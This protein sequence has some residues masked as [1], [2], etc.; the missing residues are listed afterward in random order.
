MHPTFHPKKRKQTSSFRAAV[1]HSFSFSG[2]FNL[3][4][5][6]AALSKV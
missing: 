4:R 5:A 2:R 3:P 6:P 1:P